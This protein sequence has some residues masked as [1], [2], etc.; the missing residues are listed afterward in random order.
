[1]TPCEFIG[2][3]L[4]NKVEGKLITNMPRINASAKVLG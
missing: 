2:C 1:M 4:F 3:T